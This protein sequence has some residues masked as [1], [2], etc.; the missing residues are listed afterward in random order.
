MCWDVMHLNG[1]RGLHILNSGLDNWYKWGIVGSSV[2]DI[3]AIEIGIARLKDVV[4]G[5]GG[6]REVIVLYKFSAGFLHVFCMSFP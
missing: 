4:W 1:T 3:S 5:M 2:S 6:R